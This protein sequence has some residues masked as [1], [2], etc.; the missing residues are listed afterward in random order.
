MLA[1]QQRFDHPTTRRAFQTA[2][3]LGL[4]LMQFDDDVV[5]GQVV[6]GERPA[7]R[8]EALNGQPTQTKNARPVA[9]GK[10]NHFE[11]VATAH[12]KVRNVRQRS[13]AT[14]LQSSPFP[15]QSLD[16]KYLALGGAGYHQLQCRN[17]G[18]VLEFL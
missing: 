18:E 11:R 17:R 4:G 3:W 2:E 12:R 10:S 5:G 9:D 8:R 15:K 1:E 16:N 7:S 14:L 6:D 13:W